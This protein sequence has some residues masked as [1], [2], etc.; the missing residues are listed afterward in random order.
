MLEW[1]SGRFHNRSQL[2][3]CCSCGQSADHFTCHNSSD[4]P[5]LL[6]QCGHPT[7]LHNFHNTA[8]DQTSGATRNNVCTWA[9]QHGRRWSHV[10]PEEPPA[11]PRLADLTFRPKSVSS[12][13]KMETPLGRSGTGF[14]GTSCLL[15]NCVNV[16]AVPGANQLCT[17]QSLTTRRELS[18]L[19]KFQSPQRAPL[20]IIVIHTPSTTSRCCGSFFSTHDAGLNQIVPLAPGELV[21]PADQLVPNDLASSRGT[22]QEHAWQCQ[23]LPTA[24]LLVIVPRL[25]TYCDLFEWHLHRDAE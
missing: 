23:E 6:A 10:I 4:S 21:K 20:G 17:F 13:L 18:Q 25:Q 15:R 9:V 8:R 5:I 12:R 11:A 1:S 14:L 19:H 16:A 7:K 3:G 24:L 22:V 2:L